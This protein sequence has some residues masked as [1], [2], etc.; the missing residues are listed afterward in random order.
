MSQFNR[1]D[2]AK[3]Q[4]ISKRTI[5]AFESLD[6]GQDDLIASVAAI[7]AANIIGVGFS[8]AFSA[9]RAITG[10][11][12]IQ[13]TD[14]GP[15]G[16][17]TIGLTP[18][19]VS[20]ATYGSASFF[21]S[22]SVNAQGR[23]TLAAQYAAS[24]SNVAEGANLY[25]TT[26]RA[27]TSISGTGGVSYNSGTGV[28]SL[29]TVTAS[30]SYTPTVAAV[31]NGTAATGQVSHYMRV[32]SIVMIHGAIQVT[33]TVAGIYTDVFISLPI[34]SN[35][36]AIEDAWG[37]VTGNSLVGS[38]GII[39]ARASDDTLQLSFLA[40]GTSAIFMTFSVGYRILP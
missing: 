9:D 23:I 27:R 13:I 15:K 18:S 11:A 22:F 39:A 32:G 26:T 4:G 28:I 17:L 20:A 33:P 14:G 7:K 29:A 37:G 3:L 6:F 2:L 40:P 16:N 10:S 30:G 35:F 25:F 8:P 5:S 24:T 12:D 19:G 31:V 36:T 21:T 34:A 38:S 1:D